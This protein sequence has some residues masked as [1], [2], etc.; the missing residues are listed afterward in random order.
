M[1]DDENEGRA[2]IDERALLALPLVKGHKV[3]AHHSFVV[4]ITYFHWKESVSNRVLRHDYYNCRKRCIM[5]ID[6]IISK[7]PSGSLTHIWSA[8]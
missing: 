2:A 1:K 6:Q 5:H 4:W 3:Y 8:N 7:M